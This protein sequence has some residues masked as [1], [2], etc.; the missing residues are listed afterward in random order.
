MTKS[1]QRER[2][3]RRKEFA[4]IP[5]SCVHGFVDGVEHPIRYWDGKRIQ[6]VTAP[7]EG[8]IVTIVVDDPKKGRKVMEG[9]KC[10]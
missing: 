10:Q 2:A 8:S 1:R 5:M 4:R 7:P 6:F 9:D 3:K